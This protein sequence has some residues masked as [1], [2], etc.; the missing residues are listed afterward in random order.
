[1]ADGYT[2]KELVQELRADNK[3]ALQVQSTILEKIQNID[4]HLGKLNSKVSTHELQ[5]AEQRE[6]KT[7]ALTVWA[8]FTVAASTVASKIL[9]NF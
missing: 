6:F 2:L 3:Q 1:M 8:V 5:I 9:A 4:D 7:K